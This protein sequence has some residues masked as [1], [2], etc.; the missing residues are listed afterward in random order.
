MGKYSKKIITVLWV[1]VIAVMFIV[2]TGIV[3]VQLRPV[4]RW[5]GGIVGDWLSESMGVGVRV[6]SVRYFP[7]STVEVCDVEVDDVEGEVMVGVGRAVADV[8]W[9]ELLAG[10]LGLD[11]VKIDSVTVRVREL[12]DGR[13]NITS[14]GGERDTSGEDGMGVSVGEFRVAEGLVMCELGGSREFRVRDVVIRGDDIVWDEDSKGMRVRNLSGRVSAFDDAL[15]S[16]SGDLRMRGDTLCLGMGRM[17]VGESY[18]VIDTVEVAWDSLGINHGVVEIPSVMLAGERWMGMGWN[19]EEH[20]G[21]SVSATLDEGMVEIKRLKLTIGG[22]SYLDASGSGVVDWGKDMCLSWVNLSGNGRVETSDLGVKGSIGGELDVAGNVYVNM[23]S[24]EGEMDMRVGSEVGSATVK[25][26]AHSVGGWERVGFEGDADWNLHP[27]AWCKGIVERALGNVRFSG[28]AHKWKLSSVTA[29]GEMDS[30]RVYGKDLPKFSFDGGGGGNNYGGKI[31]L[32]NQEYGRLRA[33]GEY[34]TGVTPYVSLTMQADTLRIGKLFDTFTDNAFTSFKLRTEAWKEN[35]ADLHIVDFALCN[36]QDTLLFADLNAA[37]STDNE[38]THTLNIRSD[39]AEGHGTSNISTVDLMSIAGG[40]MPDDAGNAEFKLTVNKLGT[41]AAMFFPD[42]IVADTLTLSGGVD[43]G[44]AWAEADIE[45][46]ETYGVRAHNLRAI[47]TLDD[48]HIHLDAITGLGYGAIN[49]DSLA[50][51]TVATRNEEGKVLAT[52]TLGNT[53]LTLGKEICVLD[54]C[55]IGYDDGRVSVDSFRLKNGD[56]WLEAW[57]IISDSPEDTLHVAANEI[58]LEN[59]LP[60]STKYSLAG[61]LYGRAD[62][63]AML[64][65]SKVSLSASID[66]LIVNGDNLEKLELTAT[67]SPDDTKT[68]VGL[69]I[70]TGRVPRAVATGPI[71]FAKSYMD[72]KFDIDSLSTGFLNFYLDACIDHWHGTTSGKLRLHG[73]LSDLALDSRL[74]M[75][76]DNYF[77][78]MQTNVTYHIDRNDSLTISPTSLDFLNI[79]FADDKGGRAMFSGDISHDMFSNLRYDLTFDTDSAL[80][81]KTTAKESPSYYGTVIGTGQMRV[82]GPTDAIHIGIDARTET[83]STFMVVPSAKSELG[84]QS[85]IRIKRHDDEEVSNKKTGS[86]LTARLNIGV[87]PDAKM[88]VL[89]VNQQI[90]NELVGH[91]RGQITVNIS[92]TGELT[93]QG[94]YEIENGKNNFSYENIITKEFT[95]NRGGTI[96]W[97]GDPYD[98]TLDITATYKANASLYDLVANTADETSSDL[99]RRV[100]VNCNLILTNK[101]RNPDVRF[102]IEIPSSQNTSQY[103]FDQY[104]NTQ[105]EMNRQAFSLLM[106]NK[107]YTSQDASSQSSS[108]GTSYLSTMA[109]ETL[110]NK[111]SSVISQN[112]KNIN[113]GVNYRPGDEVTNEEYGVSMATQALDGKIVMSGNIGYGRDAST[114]SANDGSFVG[115]FDF[116]VSLNRQGTIKAKAYTHANNDVIY[117]TSPTTQGVGISFQEEFDS[118]RQLFRKYWNKIFHRRKKDGENSVQ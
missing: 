34:E 46:V 48:G 82:T 62:I 55:H 2:V 52:A 72:L 10:R 13:V 115:D 105:E 112:D 57:G 60:P 91:G 42:I 99:K 85:S 89:I 19:I 93:M 50:I 11:V 80:L 118:F 40:T 26:K 21:A 4:Q 90:E 107:F 64:G 27:G 37:F 12:A 1:T 61:D 51:S 36:R 108:Q 14:L 22:T 43:D 49:C 104:V 111:F 68:M 58:V 88:G 74:Q 32:E 109:F 47:S 56:H 96:T 53:L 77:R 39:I 113:L 114:S 71:D 73:P 81:L 84:E 97:N 41:I 6:E 9:S 79:R 87:T 35:M 66:S 20:C 38:G 101:L 29:S 70:V 45:S 106:A 98:A 15:C 31:D 102:D 92:R 103:A 3:L 24:G 63:C 30:L 18:A 86:G 16:V 25:G 28:Y 117:E 33:I 17:C 110:S 7:F 54:S 23:D 44:R 8:S 76:N 67:S 116:E 59:Y 95:V 5:V 65:S 94:D 75:N 100:P 83:G 69:S 78:V